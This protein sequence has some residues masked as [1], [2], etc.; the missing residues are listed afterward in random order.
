MSDAVVI[1]AG[2]NGLVAANLLADHGWSVDVV[3]AEP[4]PGGAVRSGE[5]TL[6]GFTHDRFSSFY[7]LAAASPAIRA[8]RLE[9]HGLRWCRP[10]LPVAHPRRD[11]TVAYVSPDLD[12]TA[13]CLDGFAPGDG[14]AWRRLMDLWDRIGGHMIDALHTPFPQVRPGARL[15][16]ELGPRGLLE[17]ARF[18]VL[19]VRRLADEEFRGDGGPRLIAGNAMHADFT[20]EL[21]GSSI[22][23]WVLCGLA[24][25]VGFPIPEGGSGALTAALVRRL[26]SKGGRVTCSTRVTGIQVRRGRAAGVRTQHGDVLVA[27]KAVLAD[28]GAPQLYLDLLDRAHVPPAVLR[29][30]ERFEYGP[31]TFKLDFALDGPIPWMNPDTGRA[32]TVH[33]AEG[34]DALTVATSDIVLRRV[35]AE[36]FLVAGQYAAAD[37][38]RMPPGKEIFWAYTH[39]PQRVEAD[40]GDDGLTGRWDDEREREAFADRMTAQIEAVAPGFGDRVLARHVTTPADLEAQNANL[41][42]G[43][44]NGG[45][46]QLHQELVFRPIPGL[47][48][49]E[50]PVAGLYLA[51]SSAYPSGGVH[52]A[53]GANAARSALREHGVLR[54][55][56]ARLTAA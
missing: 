48:R 17:F 32:G 46:A 44:L 21:P 45:T 24:Q 13:A 50:T 55:G 18:G 56:A 4:E 22:F 14:D 19:P 33:L 51:S 53:C 40:A 25:T 8:L 29:G 6:P 5:L 28:V 20:P 27:G 37:P 49:S 47:G 43:A 35:A 3:E 41:V 34:L 9:E 30:I 15:V 7:P 2:P 11:G 10:P 39:I 38:T 52:G 31:S 42:G 12:E 26:E 36:P 16:A 54:R 23:G 1:G